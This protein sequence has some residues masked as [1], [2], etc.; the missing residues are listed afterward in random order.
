MKLYDS[1]LAPNPRRV[2]WFLAEKGIDDLEIVQVDLMAGVHKT[3]DYLAEVGVPNVPALIL[4]D[5]TALTESIAIC[6]YLES[7]HPEPNQFGRDARETAVIEM[8]TRRAELMAAMPLMQAVR[9]GHPALAVLETQVPEVAA[10][11]RQ[12]AERALALFE[13]RL[14]NSE[15][16]AAD[17]VTMA[18]GVLF[19]G[20]EFSRMVRFKVPEEMANLTRWLAAMRERASATAGT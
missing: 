4:D 14:E 8:W 11:C 20:I 5:G 3:K 9:H 7:L 10:N 12:S 13:R 15:W 2:R 1:R 18:D 16:L 6:R 19:T 17:R